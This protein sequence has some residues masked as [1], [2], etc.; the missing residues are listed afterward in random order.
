MTRGPWSFRRVWGTPASCMGGTFA[1][2]PASEP[3]IGT[4]RMLGR[5]A[6]A[7]WWLQSPR[8]PLPLRP[9]PLSPCALPIGGGCRA[10]PTCLAWPVD[11]HGLVGPTPLGVAVGRLLLL[12]DPR[13]P[14][15]APSSLYL[16]WVGAVWHR[17][18][19]QPGH[20]VEFGAFLGELPSI[21]N[22]GVDHTL[23][24]ALSH[25]LVRLRNEAAAIVSRPLG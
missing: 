9:P 5:L 10:R 21:L 23:I 17:L 16:G 19:R 20:M 6:Q 12:G 2:I 7:S 24:M 18:P 8:R 1:R 4:W 25:T 14:L 11:P 13:A 22:N 3:W 15:G